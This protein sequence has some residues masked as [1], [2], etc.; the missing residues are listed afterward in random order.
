MPIRGVSACCWA[1]AAPSAAGPA[2][3]PTADGPQQQQQAQQQPRANGRPSQS[4][5]PKQVHQ[6]GD[7]SRLTVHL[8]ALVPQHTGFGH[9]CTPCQPVLTCVVLI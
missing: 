6:K 8:V 7:V 9:E 1:C 2:G 4:Q 3:P 5:L